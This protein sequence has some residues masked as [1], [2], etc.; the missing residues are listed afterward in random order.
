MKKLLTTPRAVHAEQTYLDEIGYALLEAP[1]GS[2]EAVLLLDVLRAACTRCGVNDL[3]QFKRVED[4]VA[5]VKVEDELATPGIFVLALALWAAL[6]EN[7]SEWAREAPWEIVDSTPEDFL[8]A[9]VLRAAAEVEPH[10]LGFYGDGIVALIYQNVV[11][12]LA[13]YHVEPESIL[14]APLEARIRLALDS[15]KEAAL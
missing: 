14:R 15:C 5:G 7:P 1:P 10:F 13:W 6:I 3:D 4:L 12:V 8:A 11:S 9:V 2:K